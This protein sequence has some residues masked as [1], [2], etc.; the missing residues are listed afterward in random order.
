MKRYIWL[1]IFFVWL[2]MLS[3]LFSNISKKDNKNT[4]KQNT[5][6]WNNNR[7]PI[8][9][10]NISNKIND[11][12]VKEQNNYI[13][14][15]KSNITQ[16]KTWNNTEKKQDNFNI[17]PVHNKPTTWNKI[18]KTEKI[19]PDDLYIWL[20]DAKL[21]KDSKFEEIFT[22]FWLDNIPLYKIENKE[23]YIKQLSWD[24]KNIKNNLNNIIKKVWGNDVETDLFGDKQTFFNPEIYYKK[25]V[26]M[27]IFYEKE[28]YLVVLP[29]KNYWKYKKFMKE[30]LFVK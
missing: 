3:F 23:I 4:N 27:L 15:K 16:N 1:T 6:T 17:V 25:D 5:T 18:N 26:I 28:N 8:K 20:S 9:S 12:Q 19:I 2:V 24:Y 29:Y 10:Q 22:L 30:T 21:I 11:N 7:K 14:H 13:S